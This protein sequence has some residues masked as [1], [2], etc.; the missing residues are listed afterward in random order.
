VLG[1]DGLRLP[2]RQVAEAFPATAVLGPDGAV[3]YNGTAH[4]SPSHA[5]RVARGGLHANGWEFWAVERPTGRV[6][7]ATLRARFLH[8]RGA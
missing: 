6:T 4:P 5:A 2:L 1:V 7:L 3:R 8:E